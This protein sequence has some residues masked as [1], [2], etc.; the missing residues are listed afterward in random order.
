VSAT[1]SIVTPFLDQ[2]RFLAD[3]IDSVRAQ[4]MPHW[5]LL[6]ID[7]GS[8]DSSGRIATAYAAADPE[9]IRLLRHPDGH[10]HGAAASRNLGVAEASGEYIG[11]L[12]ADDVYEQDKIE[13]EI[14]LLRATPDAAMLYAPTTWWFPGSE[15]PLRAEKPGVATGRIHHPPSLLIELLLR[16]RGNVPCTCAVLIQRSAVLAVGGFEEDFHL[17]EDQTLWAKL[18]LRYPV[19]V[20]PRPT[21]RYRQHT[22]SA[23]ATAL[24]TGEYH[25]WRMHA[26]EKRFYRWLRSHVDA[27]GVNDPALIRELE[28]ALAPYER[29]SAAGRRWA[30]DLFRVTRSG[31]RKIRQRSVRA[32]RK[33]VPRR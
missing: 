31:T 3:A 15:V 8:R 28:R 10:T 19:F 18:F 11:F 20:S 13:T 9:R 22:A 1:V 33:L 25:P 26:A 12:D 14:A 17:Y 27:T 4:T 24:R 6:L 32:I 2:E 7:D 23:S 21:A 5:E 30:R 29:K 16:H